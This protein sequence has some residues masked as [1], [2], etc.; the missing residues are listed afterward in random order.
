MGLTA[1]LVGKTNFK[2][3]YLLEQTG[4]GGTTATIA[5]ATL[6]ADAAPGSLLELL[7]IPVADQDE[8]RRRILGMSASD[9][10]MTNWSH[11]TC[12]I[13]PQAGAAQGYEVDVDVDGV[14][15]TLAEVNVVSAA[16][17]GAAILEIAYQ[18]SIDR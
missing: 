13:T 9:P 10:D 4:E 5:N 3:R 11:A 8:A 14:T 1:T 12:K 18:H 16:A 15:P 2:L 7:R 6:Q 17:A